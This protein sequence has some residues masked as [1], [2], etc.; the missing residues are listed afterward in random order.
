MRKARG[1]FIEVN[2]NKKLVKS[3]SKFVSRRS[4][5]VREELRMNTLSV[6]HGVTLTCRLHD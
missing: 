4:Q 2:L 3:T 1:L 5:F 6:K